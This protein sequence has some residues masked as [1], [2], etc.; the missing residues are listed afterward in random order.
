MAI[1][2]VA[3]RRERRDD[4]ADDW[5]D[6]LRETPGVEVTATGRGPSARRRVRVRATSSGVATLRE[7][8]GALCHIEPSTPHRADPADTSGCPLPPEDD[9]HER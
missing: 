8:L 9:P 7:R 1:Y 6:T 2:I 4:V 5:I 3:V